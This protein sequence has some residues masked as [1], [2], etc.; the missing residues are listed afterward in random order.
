MSAKD[1]NNQN[2]ASHYRIFKTHLS[3]VLALFLGALAC[4]LDDVGQIA[5]YTS[6]SAVHLYGK[7]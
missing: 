1:F 3:A 5:D 6:M 4:A 7:Q 2:D